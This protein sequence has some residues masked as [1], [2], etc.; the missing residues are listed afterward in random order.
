MATTQGGVGPVVRSVLNGP[1]GFVELKGEVV[2]LPSGLTYIDVKEGSGPQPKSG[3]EVIV[4]GV[5]EKPRHFEMKSGD[6][7]VSLPLKANAVGVS[8]R[9]GMA[10]GMNSQPIKTATPDYSEEPF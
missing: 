2:E 5:L 8:L 7:G 1:Q 9:W 10:Q 6:V 4:E 3:Q